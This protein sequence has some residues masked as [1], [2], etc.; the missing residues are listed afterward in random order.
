MAG[1][2]LSLSPKS[3]C[4]SRLGDIAC[5]KLVILILHIGGGDEKGRNQY[6]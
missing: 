6:H 3:K 1:V 2:G 4:R 5:G